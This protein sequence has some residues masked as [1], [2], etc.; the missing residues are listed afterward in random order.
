MQ[1]RRPM[2][3]LLTA[4]ALLGGSASLTACGDPAGQDRNDGTTDD[5]GDQTSGND[6]GSVEQGGRNNQGDSGDNDQDDSDTESI[7]GG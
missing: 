6:P 7:P 5:S 1:I 3:A 2:A 4:L